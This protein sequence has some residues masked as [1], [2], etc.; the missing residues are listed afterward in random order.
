MYRIQMLPEGLQEKAINPTGVGL[1]S[2]SW[3]IEETY[4]VLNE[5]EKYKK[6]IVLG[7]D[8]YLR[9]GDKIK[10]LYDNWHFNPTIGESDVMASIQKARDY[11]LAYPKI[12]AF[13]RYLPNIL[14]DLV[15]T[16]V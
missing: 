1:T 11:L 12:P 16:E 2:Y 13:R 3:T 5:L 15:V 14:V 9:D 10:H 7:G 6:F 8:L 4:Q